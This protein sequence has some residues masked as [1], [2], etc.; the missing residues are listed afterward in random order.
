MAES[1]SFVPSSSYLMDYIS[2]GLFF[3]GRDWKETGKRFLRYHP[4]I[5]L[6]KLWYIL[7]KL[8]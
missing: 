7:E 5:R 8:R 3:W 6:A 1:V 4:S 2:Q